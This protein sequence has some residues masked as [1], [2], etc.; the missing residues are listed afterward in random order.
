MRL[1]FGIAF[2]LVLANPAT[3]GGLRG[4]PA[5]VQSAAAGAILTDARGM[6]LYISDVDERY[7]PSCSGACALTWRPFPVDQGLCGDSDWA[8]VRRSDGTSQWAYSGRPLYTF[9]G[10]EEP[11]D[12]NG[13]GAEGG[14][15]HVAKALCFAPAAAGERHGSE[16]IV[17][18]AVEAGVEPIREL[19]DQCGLSLGELATMSRVARAD[20]DAHEMGRRSLPVPEVA[21]VANALGVPI[22]LLLE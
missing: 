9:A 20:L 21:A 11:G 16:A 3:A 17:D 19:R 7:R 2:A 10:D 6:T 15:W 18:A 1:M 22:Y 14:V 4:P 5:S 13:D 8:V 12:A